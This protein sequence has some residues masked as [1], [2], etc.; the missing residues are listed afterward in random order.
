MILEDD[1]YDRIIINFKRLI[2]LGLFFFSDLCLQQDVSGYPTFK[3]YRHGHAV[4]EYDGSRSKDDFIEYMKKQE[5][6]KIGDETV[7]SGEFMANV[8]QEL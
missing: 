4:V 8:K 1:N 2:Y 6:D 3:F 5:T 7:T